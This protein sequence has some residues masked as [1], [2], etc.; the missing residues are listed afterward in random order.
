MLPDSK[1]GPNVTTL[2]FHDFHMAV[3]SLARNKWSCFRPTPRFMVRTVKCH[4]NVH[5]PGSTGTGYHCRT[6]N[7]P[8][9][10][11]SKLLIVVQLLIDLQWALAAASRTQYPGLSIQ[12][13]VFRIQDSVF[14]TQYSG[15]RT[16][17]SGSRTQYPG[18]SIQGP[19]R[20]W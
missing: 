11:R 9:E 16:Q 1:T 15:S 6:V 20:R 2:N 4:Q 17:Y 3:P 7:T 13:S 12:D 19:L 8:A 10:P 14:R 18:L 5:E